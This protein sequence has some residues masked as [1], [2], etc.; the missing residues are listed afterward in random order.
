[1]HCELVVPD[2]FSAGTTGRYPAL[3]LLLAR[4]R[5]TIEGSEPQLLE[6]WLHQAFALE[7]KTMPAGAL[8][9]IAANRDPGNDSWLRADPVH[10]RLMRDR[11]VVMPAEAMQIS[12]DEADALCASLNEHF[13]GVMEIV[14]LD[15]GRWSARVFGKA[16]D[17]DDVPAL[18]VAGRETRLSRERDREVTEIQMVLHAHPVN[19]AREARG[20]PPINSLWLWGAGAA[21]KPTSAWKS[22]LADEP[23]VMGL[24]MLART[25][26]RS[27]PADA[28]QWLQNAPEDGRH[29]VVLDVL[30]APALLLEVDRYHERLAALEKN[31]FAPLMKALRQGRIGMLTLHV[32]NA[33]EA[34]SFETIRG[35]LRRFW[36]LAKPIERYA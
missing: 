24:A 6:R 3:E 2:L 36:R 18:Q 20:E 25:H 30:R 34:V 1:M 31:W 14:P 23:L 4:G 27:L 10:L 32:P 16:L 8:T 7:P 5:R 21:S 17:L 11:A 26:Y 33:A 12:Q 22:I 29:L 28:A 35:D 13:A 15:A 19:A 9:L